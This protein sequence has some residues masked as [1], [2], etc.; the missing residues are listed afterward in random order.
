MT[1]ANLL[2]RKNKRKKPAMPRSTTRMQVEN[3]GIGDWRG[4]I[5]L[6]RVEYSFGR[7]ATNLM[8]IGLAE[9]V[10]A[11]VAVLVRRIWDGGK[12]RQCY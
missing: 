2:Q 9:L 5:L 4:N 11:A 1:D 7:R 12:F 8:C 6:V 10:R 3:L